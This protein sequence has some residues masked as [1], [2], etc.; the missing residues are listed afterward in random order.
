MRAIKITALFIIAQIALFLGNVYGPMSDLPL[1]VE[2]NEH[3][4]A[5]T[6]RHIALL[7]ICAGVAVGLANFVTRLRLWNLALVVLVGGVLQLV[8]GRSAEPGFLEY[9]VADLVDFLALYLPASVL[10]LG[11]IWLT[12]QRIARDDSVRTT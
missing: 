9:L 12:Q 4:L 10:T 11:M 7:G 5:I 1:V 8:W 6:R 3:Y 2:V